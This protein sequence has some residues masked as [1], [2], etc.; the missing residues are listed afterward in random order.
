[1]AQHR[2]H[3]RNRN[4]MRTATATTNGGTTQKIVPL[5][6]WRPTTLTWT[7]TEVPEDWANEHDRAFD[8][9]FAREGEPRCAP[10][11]TLYGD[12]VIVS[13]HMGYTTDV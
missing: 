4:R 2:N 12:S 13:S 8:T 9:T 3:T 10:L 5:T 6:Q 1:M 7:K 11:R